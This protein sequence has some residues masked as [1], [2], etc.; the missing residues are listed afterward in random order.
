[1][2]GGP[3]PRADPAGADAAGDRPVASVPVHSQSRVQPG[4]QPG[5]WPQARAGLT[6][7]LMIPS[8]LPRF[9]ALPGERQAVRFIAIEAVIIAHF[10]LLFPGFTKVAAARSGC[11][12]TATSRSTRRPRTWSAISARRSSGVG[13]GGSS[14]SNSTTTRR[15]SWRQLVREG[16]GP[17]S[18]LVAESGGLI[19]IADL[20]QLVETDRP[21]LKF[22]PYS[23]RFPERILEHD[24][25]CLR[26]DPRQGFH[27]P[28]PL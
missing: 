22:P 6:E 18:A 7:L 24:G 12:A 3:F 27:H 13:A 15:P 20:A 10:D 19:G 1:M 8:T 14:A 26:R 16:R 2:A 5:A 23:P 11:C 17:K 9:I 28:P 21:D 25:D 4:V